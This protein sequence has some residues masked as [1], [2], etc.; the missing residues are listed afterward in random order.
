MAPPLDNDRPL[1]NPGPPLG[2]ECLEIAD[3]WLPPA[4]FKAGVRA[5]CQLAVS[6]MPERRA[7]SEAYL[8]QIS[9]N[10]AHRSEVVEHFSVFTESIL[11]RLRLSRGICPRFFLPESNHSR[12]FEALCRSPRPVLFGTF[13]VG[14][15]DILG[16]MLSDFGRR[17]A[18]VRHRVANARDTRTM[19]AV[20]ADKVKVLWINDSADFLYRFR[21]AID[22]GF[23][24]GLQC[25]RVEYGGRVT[26]FHFLGAQRSF[27]TT[28]YRLSRIVGLPVAFAFAGQPERDRGTPVIAGPIFYPEDRADFGPA[29]AAHFQQV[30][31]GLE[32]YLKDHPFLWFNFGPLNPVHKTNEA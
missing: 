11:E 1:R 8:R 12:E 27:P 23:S 14:Q 3:R 25:D 2:Y 28:I 13:H 17:V 15:S 31:T 20:F 18:L 24:I 10:P 30:L 9:G 7:N 29:S 19:E 22:E 16:C 32:N 4:V 6:L 21:E 5:G 26:A